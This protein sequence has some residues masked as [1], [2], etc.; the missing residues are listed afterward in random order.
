MEEI[1]GRAEGRGKDHAG[2]VTLS[3]LQA[4]APQALRPV[5]AEG[6]SHVRA[7]PPAPWQPGS[8]RGLRPF[9]RGLFLAVSTPCHPLPFFLLLLTFL[10]R[11]QV[12]PRGTRGP[13]QHPVNPNYLCV[14]KKCVSYHHIL[15]LLSSISLE[16]ER[17]F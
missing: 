6:S 1:R 7:A 14:K 15:L 2:K 17:C 3:L 8:A 12:P 10:Q 13:D 11:M 16:E 5:G 9:T 4:R